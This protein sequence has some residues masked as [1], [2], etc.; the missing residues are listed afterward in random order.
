MLPLLFFRVLQVFLKENARGLY[1]AYTNYTVSSMPLYLLKIVNAI[2]FVML[3]WPI[4]NVDNS[5]STMRLLRCAALN[6]CC[7]WCC[8]Q[9]RS[10]SLKFC[11]LS[12]VG[13]LNVF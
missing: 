8:V 10:A 7:S 12:L 1:S 3:S 9:L 13:S 11:I 6:N 5:T 4:M 2:L